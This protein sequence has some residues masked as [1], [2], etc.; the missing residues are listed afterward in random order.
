MAKR[1]YDASV[2]GKRLKE[3]RKER[4]LT[5][6]DL[7]KEIGISLTSVKQYELGNRVPDKF[8]L[9]KIAKYFNVLEDWIIGDS[10]HKTIFE[11]ID[12]EL[13]E[14]GL[15]EL[16]EQIQV[17]T[18]LEKNFDFHPELYS[19]EQLQRLDAEIRAFIQFKIEQLNQENKKG[20]RKSKSDK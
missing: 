13:G 5:Q 4:G 9:T 7:A 17:L 1:Q 15:A 14:E 18:W 6:T 8:N 2:V 12:A 3:L 20:S 11:R 10:E 19:A 16:R